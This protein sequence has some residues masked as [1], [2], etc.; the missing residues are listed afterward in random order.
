MFAG[1]GS[2]L[3]GVVKAVKPIINTVGKVAGTAS[4]FVAKNGKKDNV[5]G[6]LIKVGQEHA[7]GLAQ[8]TI[9]DFVTRKDRKKQQE[10][11]EE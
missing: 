6:G 7:P 8:K 11:D 5:L 1:I 10:E 2:A 3:L 9:M 4:K